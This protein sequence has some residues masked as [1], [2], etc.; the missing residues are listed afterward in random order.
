MNLEQQVVSLQLAKRLKELKVK[1]ESLFHWYE[2]ETKL[3]IYYGNIVND[4]I[5]QWSSFS[6]AE[7]GEMLPDNCYTQKDC[8]T[9][10]IEWICHRIIDENEE[11]AWIAETEADA[12]AKMLI[13]LLENNLMSLEKLD[14]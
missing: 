9:L 13:Y 3:S 8:G 7:L 1:Q 5:M 2:H 12:R 4:P 11:D 6:V 14:E 10:P